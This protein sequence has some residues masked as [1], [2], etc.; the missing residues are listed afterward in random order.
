MRETRLMRAPAATYSVHGLRVRSEVPLPETALGADGLPD[1]DVRWGE[2]RVIPAAPPEGR[3]LAARDPDDNGYIVTEDDDGYTIRYYAEYD[4]RISRDTGTIVVHIDPGTDPALAPL[5]IAGNVL[6]TLLELR[7]E[8]VLH[9]SCVEVDGIALAVAGDSGMGKSTLAAL[10]C[11][12]GA[13]LVAE[14]ALR[15]ELSNDEVVC[16]PGMGQIRLRP[17][18]ASLAEA[19]APGMLG[20]TV[21]GRIGVNA[22][23]TRESTLRL[24]AV[25]IPGPTRDAQELSVRRL[26]QREALIALVSYPRVT[27]WELDSPVRRHFDVLARVAATVPVFDSTIPWGPPFVDGLVDQLLTEIALLPALD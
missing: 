3:V 14:D 27:G 7:G 16:Y 13:R 10:F 15:L 20:D 4:F 6:A 11:A 24:G 23:R 2:S 5:G 17:G 9:A 1:V 26:G 18:A 12:Q 25:L 8:C 21:D 19:F 22:E